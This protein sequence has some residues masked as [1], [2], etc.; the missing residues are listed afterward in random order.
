MDNYMYLIF[1]ESFKEL[2]FGSYKSWNKIW[3]FI[4]FSLF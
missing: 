4:V 3:N 2:E 1:R